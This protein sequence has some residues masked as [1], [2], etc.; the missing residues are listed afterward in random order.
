MA[1]I[2]GDYRP[3]REAKISVLDF[4]FTR[5]DCTFDTL[6]V[7]DGKYFCRDLHLDRFLTSCETLRLDLP[8]TRK[9]LIE[10]QDECVRRSGLR[11]ALV[12]PICTRGV[13]V[14]GS[15]DPRDATPNFFAYAQPYSDTIKKEVQDR[16]LNMIVASAPRISPDAVDPKIKNY[17]RLDFVAGLFEAFDRGGDNVLMPDE[18][19]NITEGPGFNVFVVRDG[20]AVTPHRGM[21]EGIT[22]TVTFKLCEELQIKTHV[23]PVPTAD[24]K[25][26]D[27][28]FITSTAG[29]IMPVTAIDGEPLNGGQPGPKTEQIRDLY[30]AKH[31]DPEWTTSIDY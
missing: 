26:A 2:D 11:R 13:A 18:D 9:E 4:G 27:E 16:G 31:D 7:W 12:K 25:G 15:R 29:G 19:G 8:V 21:L 1:F 5:S 23:A 10:I 3:L 30:W 22:R 20:E 28:V 24:L 17:N 14:P 6:K